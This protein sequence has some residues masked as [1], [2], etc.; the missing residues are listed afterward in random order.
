MIKK[1]KGASLIFVLIMFLTIISVGVAVVS[2]TLAGYKN[3]VVKNKRAKNLYAS[4][5]GLDLSYNIMAKTIE[6]AIEASNKAVEATLYSDNGKLAKEKENLL[7]AINGESVTFLFPDGNGGSRILEY[8]DNQINTIKDKL[9]I[10]EENI[11]QKNFTIFMQRHLSNSIKEVKYISETNKIKAVL[12]SETTNPDTLYYEYSGE[13]K[14]IEADNPSNISI[15]IGTL[16]KDNKDSIIPIKL[17]SEFYTS[18]NS[19]GNS[20]SEKK[21]QRIVSVN[22]DIVVPRY[23][24]TKTTKKVQIVKQP[25]LERSFA[26]DGNTYLKGNITINGDIYSKGQ[27]LSS[28]IASSEIRK[29]YD[30]GIIIEEGSNVN[31]NGE[32]V[33]TKSFSLR[34][35]ATLNVD[36]DLYASNL[37]LGKDSNTSNNVSGYNIKINTDTSKKLNL[38][39]SNDLTIHANNSKVNIENFYGLNDINSTENEDE[40]KYM[41][42]SSIIINSLNSVE[43]NV[44]KEAYILGTAYIN[45]EN[46]YQTG[47][48]VAVKGNYIAYTES[49]EGEEID[50]TIYNDVQF[51]YD[52]PLQLVSS[53]NGEAS[54][55]V[56]DKAKYFKDYYSKNKSS[57]QNSVVVNLKGETYSVGAYVNGG[58]VKSTSKN[59]LDKIVNE[60]SEKQSEYAKKVYGF[61]IVSSEFY[62]PS[63]V[64]SVSTELRL[65]KLKALKE[66][67]TMDSYDYDVIFNGDTD[68]NVI[69][70]GGGVSNSEIQRLEGNSKNIVYKLTSINNKASFKGLILTAGDVTLYG[71]IDFTGSIISGGDLICNKDSETKTLTYDEEVVKEVVAYYYDKLYDENNPSNSVIVTPEDEYK[72]TIELEYSNSKQHNIKDYIKKEQWNIE[73]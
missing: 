17:T 15:E 44:E 57:L 37:Y 23:N 59:I 67:E 68:K 39:L 34:D 20:S 3:Q 60:V 16:Y 62:K 71:N 26:V 29:K 40:S 19:E 38:Y 30:N 53:I 7:R 61:G 32:I 72:E 9:S 14:K 63:I 73:K 56:F 66:D 11:F 31:I 24:S 8:K 1:K 69:V 42:S 52:K 43:L 21:Q 45:T 48:S 13:F 46:K 65:N 28:T 54:L 49:L 25:V 50:G 58:E 51:V 10:E 41:K 22:Y 33:T 35:R 4:E 6:I 70:V 12:E 27:E 5:S 47:E 55:N 2:L 36:G 18:I 64:K